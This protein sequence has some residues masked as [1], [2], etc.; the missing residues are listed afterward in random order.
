MILCDV[1]NTSFAYYE[2]GRVYKKPIC[3][4]SIIKDKKVYYINVNDRISAAIKEAQN[5][6]DLEPFVAFGEEFKGL[7]IDR[8]VICLSLDNAIIIDAGTAITIDRVRDGVYIGGLIYPG[9]RAMQQCYANIS[10][11]LDVPFNFEVAFDE[12]AKNTTDAI[13]LGFLLSFYESV[14]RLQADLPLYLSG[15][16]AKSL[17]KVFKDA[18]IDETLIFKGMQKIIDENNL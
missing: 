18:K 7:G 3:T 12:A 11:R 17:T 10:P 5:W 14:K 4:D 13:S 2:Q 16:D 9:V 6:V 8:K 1:G 15:G